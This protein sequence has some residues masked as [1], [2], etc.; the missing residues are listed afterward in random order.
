MIK[1][2]LQ[3]LLEVFIASVG[4]EIGVLFRA[5][6]VGPDAFVM[7]GGEQDVQIWDLNEIDR[8]P[9]I[10]GLCVHVGRGGKIE[11]IYVGLGEH[12]AKV[13]AVESA[14]G[15]PVKLS[16]ISELPYRP[17][18]SRAPLL[19]PRFQ[20]RTSDAVVYGVWPGSLGALCSHLY[21]VQAGEAGRSEMSDCL[22]IP[23]AL[24]S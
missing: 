17:A 9:G 4:K 11:M 8:L 12:S 13:S 1:P 5:A 16:S 6:E 23:E 18:G 14:L 20:F 21:F 2:S 3:G 24:L 15:G 19:A 7:I 22:D 10:A